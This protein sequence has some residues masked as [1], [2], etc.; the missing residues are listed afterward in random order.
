MKGIALL[1]LCAAAAAQ[2]SS[3]CS[4]DSVGDLIPH[5]NCDQFYMCFFGSQTELHCADGLLFNPEAKV[6][7][8]PANVDCGDKIIPNRKLDVQ[9]NLKKDGRSLSPAEICAAEDSEGLIFDHEYCDKYYK[10]NHGK[11]VTMPCP[12]NLLWYNPFC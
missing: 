2:A 10:C 7:D 4:P 8:W 9:K 3:S 5:R 1:L 12:P 6:C 11:P